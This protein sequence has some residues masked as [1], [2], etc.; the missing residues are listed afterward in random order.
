MSANTCLDVCDVTMSHWHYDDNC[1]SL[2]FTLRKLSIS[3]NRPCRWQ[4]CPAD[5]NNNRIVTSVKKQVITVRLSTIAEQIL[6]CM[7]DT[8]IVNYHAF[9]FW[10]NYSTIINL[11]FFHRLINC[12]NDAFLQCLINSNLKS[13]IIFL[14]RKTSWNF[15]TKS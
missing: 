7:L 13:V 14:K 9:E 10:C 3:E 8:S 15:L 11:S 1:N 4:R 5:I 6:L 2:R 12:S